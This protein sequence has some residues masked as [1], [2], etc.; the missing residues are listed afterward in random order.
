MKQ[1]INKAVFSHIRLPPL[2]ASMFVCMLV[3]VY[4]YLISER[5][6]LCLLPLL[7]SVSLHPLNAC[8]YVCLFISEYLSASPS[9]PLESSYYYISPLTHVSFILHR[10]A[11]MYSSASMYLCMHVFICIN[12]KTK[13]V[14]EKAYIVSF[15]LVPFHLCQRRHSLTFPYPSRLSHRTP[16]STIHTSPGALPPPWCPPPSLACRPS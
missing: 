12:W 5:N 13:T 15:T 6:M 1:Q 16:S 10:P 7:S 14:M 9:G 3:C 4:S 8:V 2:Y 11:Y